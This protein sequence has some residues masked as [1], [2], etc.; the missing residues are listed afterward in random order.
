MSL[1][2]I[3][4]CAA[5]ASSCHP[6]PPHS[7]VDASPGRR[8]PK[9]ACNHGPLQAVRH[10]PP[11]RLPKDGPKRKTAPGRDQ[12]ADVAQGRRALRTD[13]AS[14]ITQNDAIN[15]TTQ[16]RFSLVVLTFMWLAIGSKEIPNIATN[17]FVCAVVLGLTQYPVMRA[18]WKES[19]ARVYDMM[20]ID[21]DTGE[22]VSEK[23]A[24]KKKKSSARA[25]SALAALEG[26]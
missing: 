16:A 19:Y 8:R 4:P 5:F 21:P 20:G 2:C 3:H 6:K 25:G 23:K 11:A 18:H 14:R 7:P 9:T 24:S 22:T 15:T 13:A 17:W 10:E 26:H 1:A 12:H